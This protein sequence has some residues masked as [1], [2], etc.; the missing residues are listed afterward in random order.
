[1]LRLLEEHED[2]LQR[3]GG[4]EHATMDE[5]R[6]GGGSEEKPAGQR[7]A[8]NSATDEHLLGPRDDPARPT[9][10]R[11]APR[12]LLDYVRLSLQ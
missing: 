4:V 3:M 11:Q 9:R 12:R 6:T 10:S 7:V 1:M 8:T 2:E 5:A